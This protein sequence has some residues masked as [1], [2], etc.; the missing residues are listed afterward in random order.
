MWP[1]WLLPL[2]AALS[3]APRAAAITS[4]RSARN[5]A[6]QG[7]QAA[8][9]NRA[10]QGL[11][12]CQR[13]HGAVVR[14]VNQLLC[15]LGDA[16]HLDA[17]Q[18]IFDA[19]V[20]SGQKPSQVTY[21]TLIARAG[22]WR[23]PRR[24]VVLYRDMMRQG[25]EPDTLTCNSLINAFVK[26]EDLPKDLPRA[27][28]IAE[29]MRRRGLAPTIVTYNTLLDGCARARNLTLAATTLQE[30]RAA[31][32][33]PTERT[34]SIMIRLCAR[35]NQ[36]RSA[37]HWLGKMEAHGLTPNA[38]T[39]SSLIHGCGCEGQ[40]E[41][42]FALLA[43]MERL[44]LKPNVVTYTSLIHACSKA[45]EPHRALAVLRQMIDAG[46]QPNR[47]TCTALFNG[48]I[49]CGEV[50]LAREVLQYMRSI[51][52]RPS[53]HS[54]TVLLS[55]ASG[56][57]NRDK[58]S[59]SAAFACLLRQ[60]AA[61]EGPAKSC[62]P[63]LTK[64]AEVDI[65][66][67]QADLD[68]T[69]N[70]VFH[71]TRDVS[72]RLGLL[73]TFLNAKLHPPSYVW[74]NIFGAVTNGA[75]LSA[76][77]E[78]FQGN[79]ELTHV[80]KGEFAISDAFTAPTYSA[81]LRACARVGKLSPIVDALQQMRDLGLE[82]STDAYREIVAACVAAR[83]P[84]IAVA[85]F[86][87]M[88]QLGT[89]IS[90]DEY[91]AFLA[92]A[93]T[94]ASIS[95]AAK[96]GTSDLE[97]DYVPQPFLS[98]AEMPPSP[99]LRPVFRIFSEMRAAGIRPDRAAFNAMINACARVGDIPRADGAFAEMRAAGIEPDTISYASLLKACSVSG[100]LVRAEKIWFEMQQ[101]T[102]HFHTF[103]PP[104]SHAYAHLMAVN[105]RNGKMERVLNLYD[106]MHIRGIKL[107][108]AHYSLAL[109]ACQEVGEFPRALALYEEMR[110]AG[111]RIDSRGLLAIGRLCE[112]SGRPDIARRIRTERSQDFAHS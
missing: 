63:A 91:T 46:V 55:H 56:P 71:G 52:L 43:D 74:E 13:P 88:R 44:S 2:A 25:L 4:I 32:L 41:R 77:L 66:A 107:Q 83:Q 104:S 85:I 28:A 102:N 73:R 31:R 6:K 53:A 110:A 50:V 108:T 70:Y 20:S 58:N 49:T 21:G 105:R 7:Q 87:G 9:V 81:L 54:F 65:P 76:S 26:S 59:H 86:E 39:Y 38:I 95:A 64:L 99:E 96:V 97:N 19:M 68:G 36:I 82:P 72:S 57:A 103:T 12:S 17:A 89:H 14:E 1:P 40:L 16:G 84:R 27:V 51:G 18:R 48:C 112:V 109:Q 33:E 101:R 111:L 34:F 30:L 47:V 15:V 98:T 60:L 24:A 75:E 62:I 23:Q 100:D 69:F 79:K 93:A 67:L 8:A 45:R 90:A 29:S 92:A 10:I 78:C 5:L 106:E 80:E 22:R 11:E 61:S 94:P 37:F 42:A 3:A 35:T